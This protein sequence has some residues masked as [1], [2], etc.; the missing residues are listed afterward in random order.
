MASSTTPIPPMRAEWTASGECTSGS[1]VPPKDAMRGVF[2][3]SATTSTANDE[4][5]SGCSAFAGQKVTSDGFRASFTANIL[6]Y[7]RAAL[8]GKRGAH[9][10]VVRV[11]VSDG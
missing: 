8:R 5:H 6:R 3:G 2:G 9:H 10:R 11:H 1:T 7:L 4:R